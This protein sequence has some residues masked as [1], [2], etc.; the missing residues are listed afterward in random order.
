MSG[1]ATSQPLR[2]VLFE[3]A[4]QAKAGILISPRSSSDV[5]V[6]RLNPCCGSLIHSSSVSSFYPVPDGAEK[7][8]LPGSRGALAGGAHYPATPKQDAT[9]RDCHFVHRAASMISR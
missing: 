5:W 9:L 7:S 4:K 3:S 2:N 6:H 1:D 8:K